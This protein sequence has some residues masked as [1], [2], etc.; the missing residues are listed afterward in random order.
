MAAPVTGTWRRRN[1]REIDGKLELQLGNKMVALYAI[2][3]I[4][5][6]DDQLNQIYKLAHRYSS[7]IVIAR[8]I[9]PKIKE[10]LRQIHQ[11]YLEENGNIFLYQKNVCLLIEKQPTVSITG[12]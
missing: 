9:S 5:L 10:I 1:N 11:P 3:L 6:G 8:K 4:D 2:V 12:L 7:F